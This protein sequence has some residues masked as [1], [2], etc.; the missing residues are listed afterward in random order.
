VSMT[1]SVSGADKSLE[2]D[3][4]AAAGAWAG[5]VAEPATAIMK[6]RA[7]FRTGALRQGIG[8]RVES[9][10]GSVS[11]VIYGTASYL[12]FILGGTKPHVIQARN[13]RALRWMGSGGI[14]V[15]FAQRVNHPGTKPNEFPEEAMG[16]IEPFIVSEFADAM[17][18]ALIVD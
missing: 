13:A 9:A 16:A 7:P 14:G 2:F 10:P 15:N 8:S 18:E 1:M 12:P 3:F 17:Q 4:E 5:A 11:V 6:A